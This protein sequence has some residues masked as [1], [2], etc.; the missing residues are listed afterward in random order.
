MSLIHQLPPPWKLAVDPPAA[1]VDKLV[2]D[3]A[4]TIVEK[5]AVDELA[6]SGKWRATDSVT[7]TSKVTR[8]NPPSLPWTS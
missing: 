6:G 4:A 2:V 5:L 1:A 7:S 8:S 3:L